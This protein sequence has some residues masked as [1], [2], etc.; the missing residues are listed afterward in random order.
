M[1][2]KVQVMLKVKLVVLESSSAES[3]QWNMA[4]AGR[5]QLIM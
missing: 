3:N 4:I 5:M 2:L 1:E